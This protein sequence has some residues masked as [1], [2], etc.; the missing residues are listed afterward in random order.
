MVN[1]LLERIDSMELDNRILLFIALIMGMFGG[2]LYIGVLIIPNW[3]V[4]ID[5]PIVYQ[6][7]SYSVIVLILI[8]LL[9]I[10]VLTIKTAINNQ[11]LVKTNRELE[12]E[13]EDNNLKIKELE[14]E[15][16]RIQ[17]DD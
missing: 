12:K 11:V 8:D 3:E 7:V 2:L 14:A 16:T 1:K 17:K 10:I 6:I 15:L 4:F 13:R 9:F 5:F